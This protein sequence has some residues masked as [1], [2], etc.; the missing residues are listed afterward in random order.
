MTATYPLTMHRHHRCVDDGV[1][2]G[3]WFSNSQPT[4][5]EC[6]LDP[7][8][9]GSAE[10]WNL[11]PLAD[12]A[13]G[14][15]AARRELE[16]LAGVPMDGGRD[17]D[18]D[19]ELARFDLTHDLHFDDPADGLAFLNTAAAMLPPLRKTDVWRASGGT[20]QTVYLRTQKAGVVRERFY[21]KGLESGSHPAGHR[22]RIEAQHRL[23]RRHRPSP[24]TFEAVNH[25]TLNG[26]S[27]RRCSPYCGATAP[28]LKLSRR[29]TA[30]FQREADPTSRG[31][32]TEHVRVSLSPMLTDAAE[33]VQDC[34]VWIEAPSRVVRTARALRVR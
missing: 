5:V 34:R 1:R 3:G 22:I 21:D 8:I 7:L 11:R 4:R 30:S 20:P 32:S 25:A 27:G 14:A 19:A 15:D 13:P 10:T 31:G 29:P 17:Y 6:R 23:Q 12:V 33:H 16:R 26:H 9:T 24:N 18:A 2:I 28:H